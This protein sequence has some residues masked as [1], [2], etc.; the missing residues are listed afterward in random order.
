MA[1]LTNQN[2][3]PLLASSFFDGGTSYNAWAF[4]ISLGGL[5]LTIFGFVVTLIQLK[6]TR[7]AAEAASKAANAA[8]SQVRSIS[9]IVIWA[10]LLRYATEVSLAQRANDFKTAALRSFDLRTRI[11]YAGK[12]LA[13]SGTEDDAFW[14]LLS[15]Q[16]AQLHEHYE[17]ISKDLSLRKYSDE[18]CVNLLWQVMDKLITGQALA[19]SAAEGIPNG[20]V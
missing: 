11:R 12:S 3:A 2:A 9:A 6:R 13:T 1:D 20:S 19:T 4:W 8:R 15:T 17:N 7:H 14:D 5:L 10:E 18:A 16:I